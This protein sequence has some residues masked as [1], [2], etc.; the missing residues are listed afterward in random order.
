MTT[1]REVALTI[2]ARL[3]VRVA[4]ILAEYAR[5]SATGRAAAVVID[6][7]TGDL[8]ASVSY[9][10]PADASSASMSPDELLDRPRYGLYPPGSTFKLVTAAAALVHDA[11]A[12]AQTFTCSR[13]P[14]NRVGARVAGYARP[15]RDDEMDK[16][17]H[18]TIDL[19][20]AIVVSCN[21]YFAQLAV[22]LGP[23]ALIDQA[24]S[25]EI[26]LARN[27]SAARV[28]DTLPQVGYGQGEVVASPLRM[29]RIAA[30]FASDGSIRETRIDAGA[31]L[32]PAHAFVPP[33]IAAVLARDM[34]DVVLGGTGHALRGSAVPIAG[35]TGTAEVTGHPSHSWFVGFAPY[36]P[37]A[38]R[39]A[40]AVILENAGYGG[41]A[42]APAAGD[43]IAAAA[44]LGLAR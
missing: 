17:P 42:A 33:A 9:P 18:G 30:A 29:A 6:P 15:I 23:R 26:A 10:W 40:V 34:R 1:R 35:K 3:Q 21:A 8:L 27:N 39:V 24:A 16:N 41:A 14:D 43:I 7:A 5:K 37:A 31:P 32:P 13:L 19:H 44:A 38:H 2:D 36:G 11:G 28:R 4:A 22:R 25:A 12:G 20:R